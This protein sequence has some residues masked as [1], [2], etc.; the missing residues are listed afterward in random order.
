MKKNDQELIAATTRLPFNRKINEARLSEGFKLPAIK[1][2]KGKSNPQDHLD[3]FNDLIE[4]HLVSE[5]AKCRVFIVTLRGGAKKWLRVVLTGL[6]SSWQEL[7]TSFLQHF[8]VTKRSDVL[9][10]HLRNVKA[11]E[12]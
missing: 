1:S 12:R 10:A 4:L 6:I 5:M 7:S 3:H 8:Q 9:L 2:Y 11:K